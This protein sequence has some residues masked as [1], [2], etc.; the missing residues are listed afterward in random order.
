MVDG[1]R[2]ITSNNGN[3]MSG[4]TILSRKAIPDDAIGSKSPSRISAGKRNLIGTVRRLQWSNDEPC[5][6]N[7]CSACREVMVRV[8]HPIL[9]PWE[10]NQVMKELKAAE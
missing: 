3:S 4:N 9:L 7:G 5:C 2:Q 10:M 8:R 1:F 6:E